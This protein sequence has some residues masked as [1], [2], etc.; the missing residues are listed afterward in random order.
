MRGKCLVMSAIFVAAFAVSALAGQKFEINNAIHTAESTNEFKVAEMFKKLVE[1]R[2]GGEIAVNNFPNGTLGTE[3]ENLAQLKTGEI[4][5]A[6][7]GSAGSQQ[8]LPEYD[9]TCFPFGFPD[10]ESVEAYWNGP[11]GVTMREVL[12]SRNNTRLLGLLRRGPRNLTANKAINSPDDLKGLKLRVPENKT[13]VA[14]W[15]SLGA[16]TTPVNWSETYTALQTRVV[17][18]QE[19]PIETIYSGKI[20]E[21][22]SHVM[23]TEHLY[24]HFYFSM[25]SR[26]YDSLTPE[27]QKIV[28]DAAAEAIAWGNN[29]VAVIEKELLAKMEQEG[30]KVVRI[31]KQEWMAASKDG[32]VNASKDL[33]P[34]AREALMEQLK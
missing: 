21:V 34:E 3:I 26:F 1:E 19:N 5:M 17:D 14:V 28:N 31:N 20:N 24:V 6:V 13:W 27:Y 8:L 4:E 2:S 33:V 11:V 9:A 23:I 16:L 18:A 15:G 22:Q 30:T 29:N 32:I 10:V 25:G 12:I 7:L